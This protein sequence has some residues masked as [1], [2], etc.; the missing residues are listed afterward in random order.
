MVLPP[1][2]VLNAFERRAPELRRNNNLLNLVVQRSAKKIAL[3]CKTTY[4]SYVPYEP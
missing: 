2:D 1:W 3:K 4:A